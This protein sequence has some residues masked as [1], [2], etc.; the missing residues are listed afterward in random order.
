MGLP[1][2][3]FGEILIYILESFV[4]AH[5]LCVLMGVCIAFILSSLMVCTQ[6]GILAKQFENLKIDEV[7]VIDGMIK[8]HEKLLR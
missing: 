8:E 5:M 2:E 3:L 1:V 6:F 7:K 4:R